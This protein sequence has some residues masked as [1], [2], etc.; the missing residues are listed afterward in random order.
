VNFHNFQ[1]VVGSLKS[2]VD[3]S[4]PIPSFCIAP[5]CERPYIEPDFSKVLF[6]T[7][8]PQVLLVSAVG[9]TGKSALAQVLSARLRLPLLDLGKHKPVGDNT[10][11]GLLHSAFSMDQ[12]GPVFQG[13]A[14][15]SYGV[16]VD[17]IDEG[18]SKTHEQAFS[19]F[20]DDIAKLCSG[21]PAT[22]FVL[23]GRT[24]VVE[25][26]WTQLIDKGLTIGVL[27]I[28]PF[29]LRRAR[30]YID[31]FTTGVGAGQ[32]AQYEAARDAILGK[33]ST[34]FTS[35]PVDR[36][37]SFLSFIGYPPVLDAIVTLL[38]EER[39][40]HRLKERLEEGASKNVEID[41]LY[42][43]ASYILDRERNEKVIPNF[44]APLLKE[45]SPPV[46][47]NASDIFTAHEQCVRLV[48]YCIDKPI[49]LQSL[50]DP[51]LNA[52]YEE[53]LG[54]FLEGVP[55]IVGGG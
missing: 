5:A 47:R 55:A 50:P 20:L 17:G 14:S 35:S 22:S 19:A 30:S 33:L 25:D 45:L 24:N 15:G 23:L 12:L 32:A 48:A 43:I 2:P 29:D 40:Y 49:S 37:S 39:N 34:A 28:E 52:R 7:E 26:C 13:L 8:K 27:Q 41:L 31:R 10:L 42:K 9:A 16:I 36:S 6:D 44:V 4:K 21:S 11:T 51:V 54:N 3:M 53:Q 1:A 18:R 46:P 38:C